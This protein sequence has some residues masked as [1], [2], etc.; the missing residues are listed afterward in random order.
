MTVTHLTIKHITDS[1][2]A[3]A[4]SD[5]GPLDQL[6]S[7]IRKHGV[8]KPVLIQEDFLMLDGA[9]R[10]VAAQKAGLTVLPVII[11]RTWAD[12]VDNF[13][14]T[15]ADALPFDWVDLPDLWGITF[16][17]LQYRQQRLNAG[18]TRKATIAAAAGNVSIDDDAYSTYSRYT[19]ELA[20]I[21]KVE[22]STIKLLRD[23]LSRMKKM[24]EEFPTLVDGL[25][26]R[27]PT[28]EDARDLTRCRYIK[29]IIERVR[30]G[31][32]S[33]QDGLVLYDI[34]T[35]DTG[36]TFTY[37]RAR[38]RDATVDASA[39]PVTLNQLEKMVTVLEQVAITAD[40]FRNFNNS[41]LEAVQNCITRISESVSFITSMRRRLETVTREQGE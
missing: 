7:S 10:L 30:R 32:L 37:R 26:S 8:R 29:S 6:V 31:E 36:P 15:D 11:C 25:Y 14:P 19:H 17:G 23:Y 16:R 12:L 9:R 4:R 2:A 41:N 28:G 22:P 18:V 40:G 5:L 34:R 27:F 39:K 35:K 1:N 20:D 33:E 13:H 3:W 24:R 38:S 21:Y